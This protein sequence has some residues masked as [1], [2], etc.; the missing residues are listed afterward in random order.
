M[1]NIFQL[2]PDDQSIVFL[3][4]IFGNVGVALSGTGPVLLGNMFKVFNTALLVLGTGIVFYTTIMGV[5]STAHEGEFMGKK[6]HGLWVPVRMVFGIATLMPT[7]SGYCA[8]QVAVMWFIIQG[9]GAAD[10]VWGTVNTFFASGGQVGLKAAP[11]DTNQTAPKIAA[12]LFS[13]LVCQALVT[14]QYSN[15]GANAPAHSQ[16]IQDKTGT[17]IGYWFGR[18]INSGSWVPGAKTD[19]K[20]QYECGCVCWGSQCQN[21]SPSAKGY[22]GGPG[23]GTCG[24]LTTTT[25]TVSDAKYQAQTTAMM[26]LVPTME[27]LADYYVRTMIADPNCWPQGGCSTTCLPAKAQPNPQIPTCQFFNKYYATAGCPT[28]DY[29]GPGPS[30]IVTNPWSDSTR[31]LLQQAGSNFIKDS[32]TM[33]AGFAL[34]YAQLALQNQPPPATKDY[35]Q[36]WLFAGAY[37]YEYAKNSGNNT[38]TY[39]GFVHSFGINGV[40]TDQ[41]VANLNGVIDDPS[42]IDSTSA[43]FSTD[44]IPDSAGATLQTIFAKVYKSALDATYANLGDDTSGAPASDAG[45]SSG[46]Q[47]AA[48]QMLTDWAHRIAPAEASS[49]NPIIQMQEF[50]H[51][52]LGGAE[53]VF[54]TTFGINLVAAGFSMPYSIFGTTWNPVVAGVL[55]Y[56]VSMFNSGMFFLMAIFISLGGLFAV[57]IP[58]LPYMLFTFGVLGW[59]IAVIE[60]MVAAPIMAIGILSPGGQHEILGRAEPA[61]MILLNIFLRPTLMIFGMIAAMLLSSVIVFIINQAFSHVIASILNGSKGQFSGIIEGFLFIFAYASIIITVVNK[62]FS[63]IHILP[64]RVLRY[65][66]GHPEGFGE[67]QMA[68]GVKGEIAGAGGQLGKA[69]AGLGGV[70]EVGL[71]ARAKAEEGKKGGTTVTPSR[72]PGPPGNP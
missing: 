66:G 42:G 39:M 41:G 61:V 71:G 19:N 55:S 20:V 65:V 32:A 21:L 46:L 33:I 62:C 16:L 18:N 10:S 15:N 48:S 45:P 9:I 47:G 27:I 31:G 57:Y 11:I 52:L 43:Y 5:L 69:G 13:N 4:Q 12:Q 23:A 24:K 25:G 8:I 59:F 17:T 68:Q 72:P 40:Q 67:E 56:L 7:G 53:A 36:G 14:K 6:F 60:A 38:D 63:L 70:G 1:L 22:S 44:N 35:T 30:C 26:S 64:D 50:G 37:Y 29:A 51:D 54:W 58:L 34:N 49:M 28:L 3:G 2:A